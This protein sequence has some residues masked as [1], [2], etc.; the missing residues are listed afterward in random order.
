MFCVHRAILAARCPFFREMLSSLSAVCTEV[1]VD[2]DIAGV[3]TA[4]FGELLRYLYTGELDG[5]RSD[6]DVLCQ[7]SEQFGIPNPL[8]QDLR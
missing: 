8:E 5:L 1:A 2:I 7:L 4:M 6:F 3:S